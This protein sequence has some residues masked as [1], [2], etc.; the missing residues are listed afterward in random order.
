MKYLILILVAFAAALGS[1]SAQQPA[2]PKPPIGVPADAKQ[3]NGKWYR[4]Y[5]ERLPWNRAKER[6]VA[7]GG[8]FAIVPDESTWAFIKSLSP[9]DLWLGG[10]DE[11]TE[12]IWKWVDGTPLTF[13]AWLG[14]GPDNSGGNENYI[15]TRTKGWNDVP[16]HG[17]FGAFHAVGFICEWKAK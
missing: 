16:K 4:V 3:F 12:G 13:T 10:T 5:L 7:V 15:V 9:A 11:A 1:A 17:N 2:Q 6:C 14:A 8:Q